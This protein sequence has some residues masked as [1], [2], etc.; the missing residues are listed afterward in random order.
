MPAETP[1]GWLSRCTAPA[2]RG[3]FARDSDVWQYSNS[4]LM[5]IMAAREMARRLKARA[6]CRVG[7]MLRNQLS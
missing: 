3:E 6:K 1:A 4:K 5:S 2:C 7:A